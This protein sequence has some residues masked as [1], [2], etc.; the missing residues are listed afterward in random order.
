VKP[1][2]E[3]KMRIAL[4]IESKNMLLSLSYPVL[5][6]AIYIGSGVGLVLVVI[7]VVLL[8]RR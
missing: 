6:S 4:K 1:E 5:A 2:N 8:L 7:V 3:G